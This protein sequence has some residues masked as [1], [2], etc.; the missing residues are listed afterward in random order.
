MT[1]M[2]NSYT[3][4]WTEKFQV[5]SFDIGLNAVMRMG[6]VFGYLQEA[7]D[8]H[9]NHLSVGHAF[10]KDTGRVW[11]LSKLFMEIEKFPAW[12]QEFSVE[13]WPLGI[14]RIFYRR[15]YRMK[16]GSDTIINACSHWLLLDLKS[17]RPT[18]HPIDQGVLDAN[19]GRLAM[20]MPSMPFENVASADFEIHKVRYSDLDQNRHVNNARYVEWIFDLLDQEVLEEKIPASFAIEY[21]HEAKAGDTVHLMKNSNQKEKLTFCVEGKLSESNQTCIR[22]RITF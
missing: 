20:D 21:K 10:M 14:E 2:C 18:T 17:R 15:D 13:T 7:A 9:A 12:G 8:H 3:P 22:S 19:A 11:V 1:I 16:V 6:S 5:R 4:V